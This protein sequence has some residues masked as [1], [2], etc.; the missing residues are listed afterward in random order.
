MFCANTCGYHSINVLSLKDCTIRIYK[1]NHARSYA[2]AETQAK[3]GIKYTPTSQALYTLHVFRSAGTLLFV[4]ILYEVKTPSSMMMAYP[5]TL[6]C[7]NNGQAMLQTKMARTMVHRHR[8]SPKT[9][10]MVLR[11][12]AASPSWSSAFSSQCLSY[13]DIQRCTYTNL[14]CGW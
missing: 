11:P 8:L 9:S 3:A 5:A 12:T 2:T 6:A 1:P 13:V 7:Q 14:P 10:G 4:N